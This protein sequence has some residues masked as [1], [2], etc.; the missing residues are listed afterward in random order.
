MFV[1]PLFSLLSIFKDDIPHLVA[2][3]NNEKHFEEIQKHYDL[4]LQII[5]CSHT[6]IL[7]HLVLNQIL[8]EEEYKEG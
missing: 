4:E 7:L 2:A 6:K 5:K 8:G 1:S 3:K